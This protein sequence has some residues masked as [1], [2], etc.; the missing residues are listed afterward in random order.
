MAAVRLL[1]V[2]KPRNV[3]VVALAAEY[4]KRIERALPI[5]W[6]AVNQ[7]PFVKGTEQHALEKEGQRL[8]ARI[9]RDEWVILLDV[10]GELISSPALAQHL[11]IWRQTGKPLVIVVGGP[12]GV[13]N[14]VRERAN[15]R[16]ALSPLT[17]PHE[18]VPI[19][20]LEQL[21]R[22]WSILEHHP[23]HK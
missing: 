15:W 19:L 21:Y 6:D 3:H 5:S 7:E 17:F 9:N 8:L 14:R 12:L 4:H 16:W 22:A 13:E 1:T 20:V 10:E 23:Y 11:G 2:G 18:L